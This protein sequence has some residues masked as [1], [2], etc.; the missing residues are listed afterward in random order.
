VAP[1]F[2]PA[3]ASGWA[4]ASVTRPVFY[5]LPAAL[6]KVGTSQTFVLT[7]PEARHAVSA[8]RIAVGETID[9]ADGGG[10]R[11]SGTVCAAPDRGPD[12]RLEIAVES[13]T[14]EAPPRTRI[15]LVQ[16]LAKSDR[17]ELA[18]ET[19]TELGVDAVVP[20][21]SERSIVRWRGDKAARGRQKW[22]SA[23]RSAAKQS[24]RAWIPDVDSVC[25]TAGLVEAL[26][27]AGR[28]YVLHEE[29]SF[30]LAELVVRDASQ[31]QGA[32]AAI[33]LVVGPE[34]GISDA[35]V[36]QLQAAGAQ[37]AC[38]GPYV[39]RS[40]TA[41]PAALVLLNHLLGRW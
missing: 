10:R 35:E 8:M 34:G 19:A 26:A 11:I 29:A 7:G 32:P 22:E 5:A 6:S 2:S 36:L 33:T 13:V 15:T 27:V 37:L 25:D 18:V 4:S 28:T 24:R 21:Q 1:A 17:S 23:V 12:P 3:S 38:L 20:W 14:D 39:L 41:G 30:S 9:I 40:S 16:A 31:P